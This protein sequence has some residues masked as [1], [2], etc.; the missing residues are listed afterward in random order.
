MA[1]LDC[2]LLGGLSSFRMSFI[3]G[4]TVAITTIATVK[5]PIKDIL[6]EDKSKEAVTLCGKPMVQ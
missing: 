1:F 6:K 2:P 5:P 3:G 4:F